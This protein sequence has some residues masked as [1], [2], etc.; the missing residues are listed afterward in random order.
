MPLRRL[1]KLRLVQLRCLGELRIFLFRKRLERFS[2][3]RCGFTAMAQQRLFV[4]LLQERLRLAVRPCGVA[5]ESDEALRGC[6][7]LCAAFMLR[8]HSQ[9]SCRD[10]DLRSSL[11]WRAKVRLYCGP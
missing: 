6:L 5:G 11:S 7:A 9:I 10:S 4:L 1:R 3:S 2:V 8:S